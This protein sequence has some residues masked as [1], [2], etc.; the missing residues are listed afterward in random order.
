MVSLFACCL[1]RHGKKRKRSGNGNENVDQQ[2]IPDDE[3]RLIPPV[4]AGEG[5]VPETAAQEL[6]K[7][8]AKLLGTIVRAKERHMIS[9]SAYAPFNILNRNNNGY[10]PQ[11]YGTRSDSQSRSLSR[12]RLRPQ[13]YGAVGYNPSLV[14]TMS[15]ITPAAPLDPES[16]DVQVKISSAAVGITSVE[17]SRSRITKNSN[18]RKPSG[19]STHDSATPS[20]ASQSLHL[21]ASSTSLAKSTSPSPLISDSNSN[22]GNGISNGASDRELPK[23]GLGVRLVYPLPPLEPSSADTDIGGRR[24][25]PKFKVGVEGR[26]SSDQS[27]TE[28]HLQTPRPLTLTLNGSGSA[29]LT[30]THPSPPLSAVTAPPPSPHS[31]SE[32]H[33]DNLESEN[34][35]VPASPVTPVAPEGSPSAS[36]PFV[37]KD[38]GEL[39]MEWD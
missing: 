38:V 30:S 3:A 34:L 25:R 10:S 13:G 28:R 5:A 32:S 36:R 20:S 7:R 39:T 21:S 2:I 29:K 9:T 31:D 8:K 19:L 35:V 33:L 18:G 22:L 27:S 12:S 24:G 1:S 23:S 26:S 4:I 17:R 11:R 15:T 14:Q 6:E 37:L 16:S